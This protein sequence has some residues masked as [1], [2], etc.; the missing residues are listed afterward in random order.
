[1]ETQKRDKFKN[2]WCANKGI[3]LIRIPYTKLKTLTIED[4]RE[5]GQPT[6]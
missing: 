3:S 1:M 2:E 6:G 5:P 4:L